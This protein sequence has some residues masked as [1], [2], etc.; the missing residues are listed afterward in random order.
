M[1][2]NCGYCGHGFNWHQWLPGV[3]DC[4]VEDCNCKKFGF[5][6][7]VDPVRRALSPAEI[8]RRRIQ[9]HESAIVDTD[10]NAQIRDHQTAILTL[11]LVLQE[12]G[13]ETN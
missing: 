10:D 9:G 13:N 5:P 8:I 7:E 2:N 1:E 4:G 12:I 3:I 11:G 6:A